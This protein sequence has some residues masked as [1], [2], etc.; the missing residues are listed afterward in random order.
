MESKEEV[1]EA[2]LECYNQ[3]RE[4]EIENSNN[5]LDI[6][7]LY[8]DLDENIEEWLNRYQEAE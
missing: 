5:G 8:Q 7:K 6:R 2:L 4:A 1:F 3:L